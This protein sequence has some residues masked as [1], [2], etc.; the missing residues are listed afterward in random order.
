M[1]PTNKKGPTVSAVGPLTKQH[2][3]RQCID[4]SPRWESP[5]HSANVRRA[6]DEA[7]QHPLLNTQVTPVLMT[8]REIADLTG[9]T[10]DSVLKTVRRL[11]AEGVV[12]A[13][14]T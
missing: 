3:S 1:K 10:H 9:S 13:N 8:S 14:E 11:V 7:Q 2:S 6:V 5:H 4:K 12:L